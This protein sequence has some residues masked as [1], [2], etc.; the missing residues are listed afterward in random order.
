MELFEHICHLDTK[1][2]ICVNDDDH[3]WIG[4]K[5]MNFGVI[6]PHLSNAKY[7]GLGRGK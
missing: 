3:L 4:V 1:S 5:M 7:M 6:F 2:K